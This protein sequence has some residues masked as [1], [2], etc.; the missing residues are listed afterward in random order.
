[1]RRIA[2]QCIEKGY[3]RF[4]WTVLDWNAPS[5]GF[6]ESIG[7]KVLHEWKVCRMTGGALAQFARGDAS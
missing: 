6:Y 3:P 1:M 7:A 2:A 5:I 4:E